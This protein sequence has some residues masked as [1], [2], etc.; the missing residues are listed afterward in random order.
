MDVTPSA[1]PF[2]RFAEL[3]A[4][5]AALVVI[6]AWLAS[7][8]GLFPK[9]DQ[10]SLLAVSAIMLLL[11]Q[12]ATTNGAAKIAAA[13]NLRLDALGAPSAD[14]AATQ[15]AAKAAGNSGIPG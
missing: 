10:L 11:G 5:V 1:S 2:G 7:I 3:G 14:V 13:A 9:D 12:R 15:I 6:G 4:V 8:A